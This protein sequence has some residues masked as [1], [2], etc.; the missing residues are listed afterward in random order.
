L[1]LKQNLN[2]LEIFSL[3]RREN[4]GEVAA[5]KTHEQPVY[6]SLSSTT[7][8]ACFSDL[9]FFLLLRKKN[10]AHDNIFSPSSPACLS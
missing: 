1:I 6:L 4:S 3:K 8:A 10:I 9:F 7:A 2:S 5:I